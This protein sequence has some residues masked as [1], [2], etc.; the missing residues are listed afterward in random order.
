MH[1]VIGQAHGRDLYARLRQIFDRAGVADRVIGGL[2]CDDEHR[3]TGEVG[4]APRRRLLIPATSQ[5][6]AIRLPLFLGLQ[7]RRVADR[8]VISDRDVGQTPG[9]RR[10][11]AQQD[12]LERRARRF[13]GDDRFGEL[14]S[15]IGNQPAEGDGLRMRQ[16]DRGADAVEKPRPRAG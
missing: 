1:A 15:R 5:I 16:Q 7:L 14:R 13:D 4:K 10:A 11:F 2:R 6:G 8:R 12:V 3:H 9:A